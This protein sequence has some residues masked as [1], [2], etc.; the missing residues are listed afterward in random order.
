M[1]AFTCITK[2]FASA[3]EPSMSITVDHIQQYAARALVTK[4]AARMVAVRFA[5]GGLQG[6][7]LRAALSLFFPLTMLAMPFMT[8][9]WSIIVSLDAAARS[10]EMFC[11]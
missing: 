9:P 6:A 3:S 4:G 10:L 1:L 5:G 8:T 7:L 2:T 11:K